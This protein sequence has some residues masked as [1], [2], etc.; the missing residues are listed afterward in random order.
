MSSRDRI[1]EGVRELLEQ[2]YLQ[3]TSDASKD[4]YNR[5]IAS[6]KTVVLKRFLQE[7]AM[8]SP[9]LAAEFEV[10]VWAQRLCDIL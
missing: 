5:L 8:G 7:I 9:D 3:S 2:Q 4:K 6:E 1:V 10:N